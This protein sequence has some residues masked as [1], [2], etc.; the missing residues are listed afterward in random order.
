[1]YITFKCSLAVATRLHLFLLLF[2]KLRKAAFKTHGGA[3][4]APLVVNHKSLQHRGNDVFTKR[5][6]LVCV[7][8]TV[9][10]ERR[11]L[12]AKQEFEQVS[13]PVKL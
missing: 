8:E 1:M 10:A 6:S 13:C 5:W 4:D 7:Q 2:N 12:D 11:M 3:T 9:P